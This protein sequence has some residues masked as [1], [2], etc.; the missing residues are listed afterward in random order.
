MIRYYIFYKSI[1]KMINKRRSYEFF[2]HQTT[3]F[4]L[5]FVPIKK[6]EKDSLKGIFLEFLNKTKNN[7]I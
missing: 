5:S 1:V 4:L 6:G 2:S 3:L 7:R